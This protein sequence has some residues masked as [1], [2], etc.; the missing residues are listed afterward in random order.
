MDPYLEHPELWPSVHAR[1]IAALDDVLTPL[2]VPRYY[3]SVEERF[4]VEETDERPLTGVAD[5][6]V[7][8]R[9]P[10]L[11]GQDAPNGHG[12][13]T[14]GNAEGSHRHSSTA[15]AVLTVEVPAVSRLRQRYL[16]IRRAGTREVVTVIEVLSPVNKRAGDGRREY[17]AK[18]MTTISTWT[19]LVEIDLLRVG[20][21]LPVWMDG[22][23]L[24][25]ALSGDYRVM[26]A[27]SRSR[28][29]AA[30]F[31]AW[32]RE[33][34]PTIAIPLDPQ[35]DEPVVD[36]QALVQAVY[37]GKRYDLQ[38]DYRTDPVPPLSPED[39]AW[40][41]RLLREKGLR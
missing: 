22:A 3:V 27:R 35:D 41:D 12:A 19:S 5:V 28:P 7:A 6:L 10:R 2:L 9:S 40:A 21:P 8:D 14:T 20:K 38:I 25:R 30:L 11:H 24:A 18:R 17:E 32:L 4:Y 26:V 39:A 1:L 33:R 23:P 29:L 36:L 16:E 15:T 34:L 13:A 37:D 31:V